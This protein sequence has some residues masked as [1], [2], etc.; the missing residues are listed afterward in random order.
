MATSGPNIDP[1]VVQVMVDESIMNLTGL[2]DVG[3]AWK[4]V[5][6]GI[7]QSSIIAI[8]INALHGPMSTNPEVVNAV[9][10]G[11]G[12]MIVQGSNF[13][14]NNI[15]IWDRENSDLINSGYTI[16]TGPDPARAR[17]FGTDE[18]GVGYESFTWDIAGSARYPTKIVGMAEY[19]I[20][21]AAL[22]AHNLSNHSGVALCL[23]NYYGAIWPYP[24]Q[25][26]PNLH[27]TNCDPYIADLYA[28][29]GIQ[30]KQKFNIV[31]GLFAT[32]DA[33]PFTN[34]QAWMIYPEGR[35]NAILMSKDPVAV[36]YEGKEQLIEAE[37]LAR[38]LS[39]IFAPHIHTAS[40]PPYSLGTDDPAQIDLRWIINPTS[41]KER[42]IST[43]SFQLLS[44]TPNPTKGKVKIIYNIPQRR[45]VAVALFNSMGSCVKRIASQV[46]GAGKHT[47]LW[48]IKDRYGR[49]VPQGVY[50]CRI[51]TDG[52]KI[53]EKIVVL[54]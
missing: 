8:K 22:K 30:L 1:A 9:V 42:K 41:I 17:V 54:K 20:D 39:P 43:H 46:Q 18:S 3:E 13:V 14:K 7:T 37:R 49:E 12:Q 26:S 52:M 29:N 32:Y 4:S 28:E 16:Y 10:D 2:S 15:I 40:Q 48:D 45:K 19:L 27:E 21:M 51:E 35:P 53:E 34:P 5:F 44:I 36:D 23:K 6:P 11:L 33:G 25:G 50:I 47:V 31:D 24:Y 38:G